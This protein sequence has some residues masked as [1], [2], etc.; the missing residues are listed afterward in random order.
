MFLIESNINVLSITGNKIFIQTNCVFKIQ[1]FMF[2]RVENLK[3]VYT[4]FQFFW[5]KITVKF[6]AS[7]I[8]PGVPLIF[9]QTKLLRTAIIMIQLFLQRTDYTKYFPTW[10]FPRFRQRDNVNYRAENL[11][12]VRH[13]LV[14][15]CR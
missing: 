5:V 3:I 12:K 14:Q 11:A 13:Y 9:I 6:L 10:F 15:T 7:W 1:Y 2:V 8:L 4:T